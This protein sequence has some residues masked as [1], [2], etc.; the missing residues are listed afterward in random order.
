MF[1]FVSVFGMVLFWFKALGNAVSGS[2]SSCRWLQCSGGFNHPIAATQTKTPRNHREEKDR[3]A[4]GLL[5][6]CIVLPR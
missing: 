5:H 2:R 1:D 4:G 6:L 3:V